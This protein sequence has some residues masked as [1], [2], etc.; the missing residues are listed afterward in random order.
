MAICDRQNRSQDG[1][2][3]IGVRD[4]ALDDVPRAP[5]CGA[6]GASDSP[7][8]AAPTAIHIWN[9]CVRMFVNGADEGHAN[10]C[11]S[12]FPSTATTAST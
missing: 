6:N 12:V 9:S 11:K 5:G 7:E 10:S 4:A 2:L 1:G 3:R 8:L